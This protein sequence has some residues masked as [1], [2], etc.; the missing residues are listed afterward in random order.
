MSRD[1]ADVVS[2][3][4]PYDPSEFFT[5]TTCLTIL[6]VLRVSKFQRISYQSGITKLAGNIV[7]DSDSFSP[8]NTSSSRFNW[9]S[10]LLL[11]LPYKPYILASEASRAVEKDEALV[12][13]EIQ[14][15]SLDVLVDVPVHQFVIIS[16][17]GVSS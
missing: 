4:G 13:I 9:G 16:F 17:I 8:P 1:I 12:L 14:E 10:Q 3:S 15:N 11:P 7:K 6:I 2:S 5:Y